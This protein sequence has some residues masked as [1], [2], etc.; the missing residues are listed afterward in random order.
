MINDVATGN[1]MLVSLCKHNAAEITQNKK[2][3]PYHIL[4]PVINTFFFN[5]A[6]P[7]TAP[8]IEYITTL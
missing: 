8:I 6:Y 3:M 4:N 1:K 2:N 7:K 5:N